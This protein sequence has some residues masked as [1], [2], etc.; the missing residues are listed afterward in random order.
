MVV[1]RW[2]FMFEFTKNLVLNENY[3]HRFI[4]LAPPYVCTSRF[5]VTQQDEFKHTDCTKVH[6]A[7]SYRNQFILLTFP[8]LSEHRAV[9]V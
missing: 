8:T 4:N 1:A 9:L 5:P 7:Q 6:H 2:P 3:T